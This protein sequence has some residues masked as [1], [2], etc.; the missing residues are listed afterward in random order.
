MQKQAITGFI[1]YLA[2]FPSGKYALKVHFYLAQLYFADKL[3]KMQ[4]HIMNM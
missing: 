2:Q 4:L 1:N 3:K